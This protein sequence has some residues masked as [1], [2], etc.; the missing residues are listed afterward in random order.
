[1]EEKKILDD[2]ILN[3]V[4]K[5][6]GILK[7]ETCFDNDILMY[8]NGAI[9]TLKQLGIGPQNGG[10]IVTSKDQ[11]FSEYLVSQEKLIEQVKLYLFYKTKL[12]F[13]SNLSGAATQVLKELILESE[14]R[15]NT[16]IEYTIDEKESKE[17]NKNYIDEIYEDLKS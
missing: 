2:S 5:L 14:W 3:S 12:S 1:M 15:L 10:Y 6:L 9:F 8:I 16:E 11:T 4:K 7:E 17:E 13:D